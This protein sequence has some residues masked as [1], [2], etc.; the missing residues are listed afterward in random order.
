MPEELSGHSFVAIEGPAGHRR[1]WGF[2]PAGFSKYD[3]NRDVGQLRAG[4][5]GVVHD[6]TRAFDKP[7][8]KTH[9]YVIS[10]AQAKAALD[11]VEEYATG[12]YRYSLETCQC[13]TFALDVMRAARLPLPDTGDTPTPQVMYESIGTSL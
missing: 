6:D 7:G 13:A 2:S 5:P 12:R 4:V 9:V 8:V 11:K 1:V 10:A 3:P